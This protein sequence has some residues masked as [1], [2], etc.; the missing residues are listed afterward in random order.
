M[1]SELGE[2]S[3]IKLYEQALALVKSNP[4]V[5]EI[6]LN[7]VSFHAESTGGRRGRRVRSNLAL[8][9]S[10]GR[11]KMTIHFWAE[12]ESPHTKEDDEESYVHMFKRWMRPIIVEPSRDTGVLVAPSPN[13]T[14][15]SSKGPA[16]V[17][18]Q[19]TR[20]STSSWLGSM[21]GSLLPSAFG[22]GSSRVDGPPAPKMR[23]KPTKGAM[24]SGEVVA[25]FLVDDS[26]KFRLESLIVLYPGEA[27]SADHSH[28]TAGL[29]LH[30]RDRQTR[31]VGAGRPTSS[32]SISGDQKLSLQH[33]LVPKGTASIAGRWR[34]NAE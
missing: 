13:A 4:E 32:H 11:E 30:Y 31:K 2:N 26:N 12:G 5:H 22:G 6:L 15:S 17:T 25:T 9:P 20:A 16:A 10:T 29:I 7:P 14:A 18:A 8:D 23:G 1:Y 24:A 21:F 19:A 3:P 33:N 28:A 27:I 34:R